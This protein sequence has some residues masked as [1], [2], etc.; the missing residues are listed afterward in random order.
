MSK[1]NPI[2][3]TGLQFVI[4]AERNG[5]LSAATAAQVKAEILANPYSAAEAD[6]AVK[7]KATDV[8]SLT[9][10]KSARIDICAADITDITAAA[11]RL[12]TLM[13]KYMSVHNLVI[14]DNAAVKDVLGIGKRQ[15]YALLS[16]L[17]DNRMIAYYRRPSRGHKAVHMVN[18][19]IANMRSGDISDLVERFWILCDAEADEDIRAVYDTEF[20][21]PRHNY[22][23]CVIRLPAPTGS[24]G[25]GM[26]VSLDESD[27]GKKKS[28]PA[29]TQ[30]SSESADSVVID[31][32][33]SITISETGQADGQI[34]GQLR[35]E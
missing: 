20:R 29:A 34:D 26:L 25:V 12:L 35:I 21:K 1:D 3:S 5:T 32:E 31:T 9:F 22:R 4:E 28:S 15:L 30:E 18:P 11:A 23:P 6:R 8:K 17:R 13:I 7:R 33:K 19:I 10:Y 16:E 14:V 27:K 24:V 2:K